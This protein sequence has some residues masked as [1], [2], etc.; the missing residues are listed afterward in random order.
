MLS[1]TMW[2]L[3]RAERR[4][5]RI[6]MAFGGKRETNYASEGSYP[7]KAIE[8]NAYGPRLIKHNVLLPSIYSTCIIS[9]RCIKAILTCIE[10]NNKHEHNTYQALKGTN[11]KSQQ[12]VMQDACF[13]RA[14]LKSQLSSIYALKTRQL[15]T[16]IDKDQLQPWVKDGHFTGPSLL[17]RFHTV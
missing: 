10:S 2:E 5:V 15:F 9:F 8:L 1:G 17:A 4:D 7:S 14:M 3:H 16:I 6:Y 13:S 12:D 11:R